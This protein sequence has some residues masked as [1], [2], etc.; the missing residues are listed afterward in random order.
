MSHLIVNG[1]S[2]I[3]YREETQPDSSVPTIL[4]L[5]ELY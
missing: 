4:C 1:L 5:T 3:C 2:K